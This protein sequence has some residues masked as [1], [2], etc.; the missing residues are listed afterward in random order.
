MNLGLFSFLEPGCSVLLN[1][2]RVDN[3]RLLYLDG[4]LFL[5][6]HLV[7]HRGQSMY[8]LLF[9]DRQLFLPPQLVAY[10]EQCLHH[11]NQLNKYRQ[12]FF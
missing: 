7:P 1:G 10:R 6:L 9:L 5:R 8:Q 4:Q 3:N 2:F 12:V 11:R